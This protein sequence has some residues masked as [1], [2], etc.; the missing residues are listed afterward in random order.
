MGLRCGDIRAIAGGA[1]DHTANGKARRTAPPAQF[2]TGRGS[3]NPAK[4][5]D[6]GNGCLCVRAL[7]KHL[8]AFA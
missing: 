4:R 6:L 3:R 7:E 5:A 1:R 2:E 8:V